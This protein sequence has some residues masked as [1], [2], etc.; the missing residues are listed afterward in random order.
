MAYASTSLKL[1]TARQI[2]EGVVI[3]PVNVGGK[4]A[5]Y[6]AEYKGHILEDV[7]LWRL[8]QKLWTANA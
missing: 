6:R 1:E 3:D 7:A 2:F 8:A 5:G 4:I